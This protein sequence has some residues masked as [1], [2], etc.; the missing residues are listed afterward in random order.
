[1]RIVSAFIIIYGLLAAV[2]VSADQ[3][4]YIKPGD[5]WRYTRKDIPPETAASLN[6]SYRGWNTGH[7][8][9]SSVTTGDFAYKTVW[10]LNTSIWLRKSITVRTPTDLKVS[11]AADNGFEFYWNGTLLE[12]EYGTATYRWQYNFTIPAYLVRKGKNVVAVRL[13]DAG[14]TSAFDMKLTDNQELEVQDGVLF[15]PDNGHYY[16]IIKPSTGITWTD[17]NISAMRM[18]F[19]STRGHLATLTSARESDF[20]VRRILDDKVVYTYWLGG[21]QQNGSDEPSGGWQWVTGEKWNFINW[22]P[23][24]PSNGINRENTLEMR[25]D[26]LWNDR[27]GNEWNSRIGYIVEF[28]SK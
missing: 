14:A 8:P 25:P 15:N 22:A 5:T 27:Y 6:S 10:P 20:I 7:A 3:V 21:Y 28:E 18:K 23:N 19:N 4:Q 9:F 26:G 17:A 24:E 12:H 1:M 13:T 2:I 16:K 11:L